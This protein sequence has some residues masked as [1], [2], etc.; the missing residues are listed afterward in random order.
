MSAAAVGEGGSHQP[1]QSNASNASSASAVTLTP[2]PA[3]APAPTP[4][5]TPGRLIQTEALLRGT[6]AGTVV[7]CYLEAAGGMLPLLQILLTFSSFYAAYIGGVFWLSHWAASTHTSSAA[8]P[9]PVAVGLGVYAA[10]S[11]AS[12]LVLFLQLWL[13]VRTSLRAAAALHK[14]LLSKLLC[15]P[16]SFYDTTP[17]GRILSRISSD[18]AAIDGPLPDALHG[19]FSTAF[20]VLASLLTAVIAIPWFTLAL[21]P[22]VLFYRALQRYYVATSR[23][24]QRLESI[25]RSPLFSHLTETLTGIACVRA[26]GC[27]ALAAAKAARL[28]DCNWRAYCSNVAANRWLAVRVETLSSCLTAGAALTAVLMAPTGGVQFASSAG[29]AVSTV[30]GVSQYCA[31]Q[32][33]LRPTYECSFFHPTLFFFFRAPFPSP[34]PQ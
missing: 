26:Y 17:S 2:A 24:L 20:N 31:L 23:E 18:I 7:Q 10:L 3:P 8:G 5:A 25:S 4:T 16:S 9:L 15:L 22:L 28:L 6:V 13:W 11:L 12:I 34:T 30:L 1:A 33:L 27:G 19:L 32:C 21:P 14:A 29:L